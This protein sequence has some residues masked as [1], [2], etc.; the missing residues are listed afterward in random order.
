[1]SD[2]NAQ[3]GDSQPCS[4]EAAPP[5]ANI[6]IVSPNVGVGPLILSALPHDTT[7][8]QLKERI[9]DTLPSHPTDDQQRLI[10]RG[11]LLARDNDTLRDVFTQELLLSGDQVTLHLVL[12][13]PV[14]HH[15]P[16]PAPAPAISPASPLRGQSPA[17]GDP[18]AAHQHAHLQHHLHH[19]R[20][21]GAP[22]VNFGHPGIAPPTPSYLRQQAQLQYQAMLR[23][24]AQLQQHQTMQ[25][26]QSMLQWMNQLQREGAQR[27]VMAQQQQHQ[28]DGVG[29]AGYGWADPGNGQAGIPDHGGGRNSPALPMPAHTVVREGVGPNGQYWRMTVNE[30]VTTNAT[31]GAPQHHGE[32]AVNPV[33]SGLSPAE[34]ANIMR[35]ADATQAT[36]TMTN[37]MHRSASGASL[38]NMANLAN[39]SGPVQPIQPGVTTPLFPGTPRNASR[40][41]TPDPAIRPWTHSGNPGA[42]VPHP[43]QSQSQTNTTQP[44]AQPEVYI[45]S[46]PTGPRG[47]LIH[48]GSEMYVTPAAP[49][50]PNPYL[51]NILPQHMRQPPVPPQAWSSQVQAPQQQPYQQQA[52]EQ[53]PLQ[54]QAQN[55]AA[56][57]LVGVRGGQ[58]EVAQQI[59]VVRP[60]QG[61]PNNPGAGAFVAAAWPH[62]WL[63]IRLVVFVW[64]FTSNDPS[65]SRWFTMVAIAI[66]VFI[67]NTGMLNGLANQA[68][69]PFRQH[70]E[71][72][73][74][75]AA[76]NQQAQPPQAQRQA[77]PGAAPAEPNPAQTAARLVAER[78]R[79]NG[80]WLLDQVRRVERASLLFLA[81][82]APGVAERHIAHLEAQER[83]ERQRR[84]AEEAAAIAAAAAAAAAAEAENSP[85]GEQAPDEAAANGAA[86]PVVD[87]PNLIAI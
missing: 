67:L 72:L 43:T 27:Q 51:Y 83:A 20:V 15:A 26:H 16:A 1:M 59:P 76:P 34:V 38:A 63:L 2:A 80:H 11:R 65:W 81:S 60:L 8:R 74:P 18:A 33:G 73:I 5:T 58:Q 31:P 52:Q 37:A 21:L 87:E 86:P 55:Q 36:Q 35:G 9:R 71:G 22:Q 79:A 23:Q 78:R 50:Q 39:F 24:Q 49:R 45:L 75:L 3:T 84:E 12:R 19:H 53:G 77:Q 14:D 41:A 30:T 68:W 17:P 54:A 57:H 40:T 70:L 4:Q 7:V 44:A 42:N 10:H 25:Q 32:Q 47:L 56:P 85:E 62:V 61:H 69:D 6:N 64:W 29:T 48:S 82:I 46:S 66:G 28:R 13:D